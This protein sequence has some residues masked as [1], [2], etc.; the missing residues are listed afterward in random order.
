MS[1]QSLIHFDAADLAAYLDRIGYSGPVAADLATLRALQAHQLASLAFE[2]LDPLFRHTPDLSA[3]GLIAKLVRGGRGGY[4]YEQNGLLLGM[5]QQI[6]FDAHG[7]MGRVRWG[8]PA[9]NL[10]PRSHMMIH[11]TLPD[12]PYLVDAGFGGMTPTGPL[13]FVPDIVQETPHEPFRLLRQGDDWLLQA[14]VAGTWNDVYRF[15]LNPQIPIDYKA[16]NYYLANSDESFFRQG[17][18]AARHVAGQRKA[19]SNRSFTIYP[20]GR[21]PQRHTL[22]DAKAV[23]DVLERE[24]GIRVPDRAALIAYI[25]TKGV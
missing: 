9:D 21:A 23:C 3:A 4:C 5:L 20:T 8:S 18:I 7:L 11:V 16:S 19:L 17:V 10:T 25:D 2:N 22:D 1:D 6:G 12:G 15:D 24:F 14:E 13:R